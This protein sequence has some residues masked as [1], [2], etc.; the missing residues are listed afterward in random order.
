MVGLS[1]VRNI[2]DNILVFGKTREDHDKNLVALCH[3]LREKGMTASVGNCKLG[4]TEL[5][6]FG[7]KLSKNGVAVGD[8]KLKALLE[9]GTPE[10]AGEVRSFMGLAVYCSTHIPNLATLADPLWYLVK[11]GVKFEWGKSQEKAL[12]AIKDAVITKSL[13]YFDPEWITEVTVDASPV[14]VAAVLAQINPS[15]PKDRKIVTCHSKTLSAVERR[16]SQVEKESLAVVWACERLYLYLF[17]KNFRLVTDNRAVELILKNPKSNPPLRIKRMALRMEEFDYTII[18]KPGAYNIADYMSRH[19]VNGDDMVLDGVLENYVNFISEHAIPRAMT[20]A[21]LVKYTKDDDILMCLLAWVRDEP[22][23]STKMDEAKSIYNRFISEITITDDDLI[24]RGDKL[25]IPVG[26]HKRTLEIAHE[27]HQGIS[28]TKALL[29]TKVWFPGMDKMVEDEI[30]GCWPC[31]LNEGGSSAQP[32]MSTPLPPKPWYNLA[33]DFYGPLPNGKELMV[34]CDEYSRQV[35]VQEVI[36]T[37][38]ENVVPKL[39]EIFSLFGIPKIV[40]SDN[41]PPFNGQKFKDFAESLGFEH[42]KVTPLH[43]AANGQAESFMK[44]IKRVIK[45]AKVTNKNWRLEM[46]QFLR[47]YR[48]TPHSTTG[49]APS[50]MFFGENRTNRLPSINEHEKPEDH[51]SFAKKND[52]MAKLKSKNYTDKR[53]HAKPH[54]FKIGDMVL[55]KQKQTNK[56]MTSFNEEYYKIIDIKGSMIS[57]MSESG[58]IYAR[59]ASNIKLRTAFRESKEPE[60]VQDKV[61]EPSGQVIGE[62]VPDPVKEVTRPKRNVKPIERL[63]IDN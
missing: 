60:F 62:K 26:L 22:C 52:F 46:N 23:N 8:D 2:A 33:M 57:V 63:G 30:S 15:N 54:S 16:Y 7:L 9:A 5:I 12:R 27:G 3:R 34:V 13:S 25:I 6:F 38:A 49:V 43:P 35:L 14:G 36:S 39:D 11:D 44:N 19:P 50:T 18:H 40:K 59:N 47:S 31:Q 1:G 20:R 42:R 24:M 56:L 61:S 37:A 55:I 45:N 17:G 28:K 29:R 32:I 41:G 21:E 53:R 10:N 58:G 4:V 48:S 51:V